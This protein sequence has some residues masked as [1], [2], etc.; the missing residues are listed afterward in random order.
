MAIIYHDSEQLIVLWVT[1]PVVAPAINTFIQAWSL[2]GRNGGVPNQLAAQTREISS[3]LPL[4]PQ[5]VPSVSEEC[6][7]LSAI[8]NSDYHKLHL[9]FKWTVRN[10]VY[11]PDSRSV[12]L[13]YAGFI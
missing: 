7:Y 4:L 12:T 13:K 10:L 8:R 9:N 11:A 2:S 3:L 1:V 5:H 6:V